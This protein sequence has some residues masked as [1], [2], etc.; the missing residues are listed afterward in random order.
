MSKCDVENFNDIIV[1]V[2]CFNERNILK[3]TKELRKYFQNIVV[4][5]DGSNKLVSSELENISAVILRHYVNLG[6]GAAIATGFE[7]AKRL[8]SV[9][10]KYVLTFDADGQHQV[11]DALNMIKAI[12]DS[13]SEVALGNRFK[14]EAYKVPIRRKVVLKLGKIFTKYVLR[15]DFV[16]PSNGMRVISINVLEKFVLRQNRMAHATEILQIIKRQSIKYI[17]VE[18]TISYTKE[19]LRKGQKNY[20]FIF[21]IRDL[22]MKENHD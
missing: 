16:D 3:V 21:I 15:L 2:P 9:K 18:N 19:S 11:S 22:I 5:D 7:F 13:K 8:K 12:R 1:L 14:H 20:G 10:I 6:Q 4:I 17:E